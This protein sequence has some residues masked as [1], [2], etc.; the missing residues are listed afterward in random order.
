MRTDI[1]QRLADRDFNRNVVRWLMKQVGNPRLLVRLWNGD[2][3]KVTDGRPVACLEIRDRRAVLEMLRSPSL[4]FGESYASGRIEIHGD[5]LEFMN[6]LTAS[7]TEKREGDYYLPKLRSLLYALR[8][9]TL[10]RSQHNVH[11][12]YDLGNDF[13]KLWLDERMVYTCAYY[14]TPDATLAEAQLAKLDHVCRKLKLRPGQKVI[15]AGCGWGALAMHMAEH[16]GVNV[17]AYNNSREQVAYARQRASEL[18]LDDR[19]T[20]VQDDYRRI[21]DRCD[22]FVSVGMLEHVGRN[23]Y[24]TLGALIKRSL[25][26]DGYGLIHSIGRSYP[27]RMD[28]WIVK[29]IFPGGHSPS[30]SEMMA[31]FEPFRFSVL[32]VENLR[33]H[34][35]RTCEAW[36]RNF[37]SVAD[38]VSDMY[39]EEFT[40]M[41]RLYLA[42]SSA[43]FRSGTLQLFQVLFTPRA[44]NKVPWTRKYQYLE[45]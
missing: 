21:E 45:D 3:F 43:G 23:H 40:R 12:H 18:G 35:A 22:A 31:I 9:N 38:R 25:K 42:G 7:I 29:H 17:L 36:F 44:N 2:E 10:S 39:S 15:E 20:F 30:L 26:P 28:P 19:V 8:V 11:H 14:D 37:E 24:K 4:G 6:E 13:Y 16:Y 1:G 32:D 5:F 33:L 34:Y 27:A 41:W